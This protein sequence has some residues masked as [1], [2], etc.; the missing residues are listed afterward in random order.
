MSVF[1]QPSRRAVLAFAAAA[2]TPAGATESENRLQ[3]LVSEY[4]WALEAADAAVEASWRLEED[5][6]LPE[7][8]VRYGRRR[9]TDPETREVTWGQWEF[10]TRPQAE[11]HFNPIIAAW[12]TDRRFPHNISGLQAERDEVLAELDR[13]SEARREA[14]RSAGITTAVELADRAC[15]EAIRV[16]DEIIDFQPATMAEV[17]TKNA[18]LLE[19]LRAGHDFEP[20]LEKIFS[21]AT[22]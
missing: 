16:R 12:A 5:T 9:F 4:R 19:L 22:A 1:P 21:S 15:T 20:D 14:E 6:A 11:R 17:A 8:R 18:F 7:V 13:Q 3:E 2:A 10:T